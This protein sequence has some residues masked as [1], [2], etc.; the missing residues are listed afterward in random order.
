VGISIREEYESDHKAVWSLHTL[1]FGDDGCVARL[2]E[3]LR[4]AKAPLPPLSFVA[5]RRRRGHRARDAQRK[6]P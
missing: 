6:P 1:A 3:A 4:I 2:V 5:S